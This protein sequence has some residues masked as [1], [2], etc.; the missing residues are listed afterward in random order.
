VR[1]YTAHR[2]G[3]IIR[4]LS[5]IEN[6]AHTHPPSPFHHRAF[7]PRTLLQP[8]RACC[9]QS[10]AGPYPIII[11]APSIRYAALP[12]SGVMVIDA[13]GLL[14]AARAHG[15]RGNDPRTA[16]ARRSPRPISTF[17]SSHPQGIPESDTALRM[18]IFYY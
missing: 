7:P 17:V 9:L 13:S 4:Y 18:G 8:S 16:H 5:A 10:T 11:C 15:L 12:I 6:E 2:S 3:Y 14:G 1:T